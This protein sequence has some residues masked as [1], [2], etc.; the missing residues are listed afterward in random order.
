ML[1]SIKQTLGKT[2]LVGLSYFDHQH[3][4]VKQSVLAGTVL[5]ADNDLGITLAL[6]TTNNVS[7][8]TNN[9]T[10]TSSTSNAQF[11]LPANLSC[12][13]I[14]PKGDFHTSAE[15]IKISDP[16]FLVTWDIYQTKADAADNEQQWWQWLPRTTPP[17]S[18][19]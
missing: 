10:D 19:R 13:F 3:N 9:T 17:Q 18:G 4:L 16:D 2:C 12:W 14:A 15:N 11:I 5:K 1:T 8:S 7:S 6:A